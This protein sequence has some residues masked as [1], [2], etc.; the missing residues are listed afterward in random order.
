MTDEIEKIKKNEW[1]IRSIPLKIAKQFIEKWHYANGAGDVS[2]YCFGLFY[3]ADKYTINGVALWNPP[4][5]GAAKSVDLRNP[6]SVLGLSRFCLIE[7]RPEN[8]G[9]FLISK[10]IKLIDKLKWNTLLTYADIGCDHTGGLYRAA[11]WC[12]NGVTGKNPV[13]WNPKTN[14]MVSKKSG[15]KTYTTAEMLDMNYEFRGYHTKRRFIYPLHN[16]KNIIIQPRINE[17]IYEQTELT[18][19]ANGKIFKYKI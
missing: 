6:G 1:S 8:S 3:K 12:F 2:T 10:S 7:G 9:S 14:R 4:P 11:N 18:F 13:W 5:P 17:P 19:T 16:R 15:K